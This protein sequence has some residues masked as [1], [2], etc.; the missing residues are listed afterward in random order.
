MHICLSIL[1]SLF[2]YM[3]DLE[4]RNF[5]YYGSLFLLDFDYIYFQ[6]YTQKENNVMNSSP[7]FNK[8]IS[9]GLQS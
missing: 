1:V 8:L 7:N 2:L 3:L 5:P 6:M 4:S 9:K